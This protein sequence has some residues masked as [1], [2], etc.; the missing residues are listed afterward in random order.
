MSQA[1]SYEA[2]GITEIGT[3][4]QLTQDNTHKFFKTTSDFIYPAGFSFNFS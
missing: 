1:E 2:P 3:F 4:H